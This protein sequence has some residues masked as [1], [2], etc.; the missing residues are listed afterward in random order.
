MIDVQCHLK[1][2]EIDGQEPKTVERMIVQSHWNQDQLVVL[3]I[4]GCPSITLGKRDLE[5]AIQNAG[6]IN[7]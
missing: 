7:R 2:Y 6:N 5:V 4:P 3:R 1:I